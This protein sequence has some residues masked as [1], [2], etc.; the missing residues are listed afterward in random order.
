MTRAGP[1]PD[2]TIG[3]PRCGTRYRAPGGVVG[4][5]KAT[6]RCTRCDHVFSA[7]AATTDEQEKGEAA[8]DL[9][10]GP[11][12][13][14]Q[15]QFDFDT[16][17]P[18][19]P[20]GPWPHE[21]DASDTGTPAF[22]RG[23][24][25]TVV[26]DIEIPDEPA[27]TEPAPPPDPGQAMSAPRMVSGLRVGLRFEVLILLVFAVLGLYL[28]ARP[29]AV[30]DLIASVPALEVA[31]GADEQLVAQMTITDVEGSNETLRGDRPGFIIRGRVVNNSG[32]AA[33]A[34][35]IEARL[36]GPAGELARKTVY[37]GTKV[38]LRLVRGWTPAAIEMFEK[39]KPPKRYRLDPGADD[40]FLIVFQPV[41]PDLREF[42]CRVAAAY[43]VVGR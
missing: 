22:V 1:H 2:D 29:Q 12:L 41:P 25:D 18:E 42:G 38:S 5:P 6:Y 11:A 8:E 4:G 35:Q 43:P 39:I 36:Y 31:A 3:C 19:T 7:D 26:P 21:A 40:G 28:V 16:D 17:V 37:A 33:G 24:P 20:L 10:E 34:I 23:R 13:D 14:A 15:H 30:Q 32:R 27:F 9:G